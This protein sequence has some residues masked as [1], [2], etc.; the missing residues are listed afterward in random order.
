MRI[1]N[2]LKVSATCGIAALALTACAANESTG[3]DEQGSGNLSGELI[4]SGASSQGSAQE[5]WIS[6][7]QTQ[8]EGVT[9]NYDP[10]GSGNGR[11]TFQ[12]GASAFAGSD[13][14]F[15][16]EEISDGEFAACK[17]GS[18]I[19]EFP[20]YISPIAVVFNL[21]GIDELQLDAATVAK[22]FSG[23]ITVWNDP[24]IASQ[25][26]G[27]DLPDTT[28]NPV[29][30]SDKSGTTENFTDYLTAA[31][32]AE[33]TAGAVEEWP[34]ELGGE[35]AQQ[36]SGMI[37]AVENGSGAIGYADASRAGDLGKVKI[38]VG[39]NYIA[40]SPEAAAA[41]VDASQPEAD[42]KDSDLAITLDRTSNAEGVYPIVLVSY[43][44]GCEE[45]QSAD[46]AKLVKEYFGYV[47]SE[48][49]QKQAAEAAGSAP[50]SA[51]LS[52][53]IQGIIAKI[54]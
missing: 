17:P 37:S 49:G 18:A 46:N 12:A 52:E 8:H 25:N 51:E 45:Y 50:L 21:P 54:K 5:A 9:V 14:A 10:A 1:N 31:A 29:H 44:I 19:V 20:A 41:V 26:L 47:A 24:A 7:F 23:Q 33:W 32:P 30:R 34:K 28:I 4:G 38:K 39:D 13:R 53:K 43:L 42:R 48:E 15:K 27:V 11:E 22:I 40:Y 2:L 35:A 6:G 3:G 36:T 16:L